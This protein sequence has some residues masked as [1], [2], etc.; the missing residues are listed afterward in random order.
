[1]F[2]G[3]VSKPKFL[4]ALYYKNTSEGALFLVNINL[5]YI[6]ACE[7]FFLPQKLHKRFSVCLVL[8]KT[9]FFIVLTFRRQ[10]FLL[11]FSTPCI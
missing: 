3:L 7:I 4:S 2:Y 10:N 11:N 1:M 5:P 8:E 6:W 9:F